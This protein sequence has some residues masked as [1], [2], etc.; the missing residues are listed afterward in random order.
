MWGMSSVVA[1][2]WVI[3]ISPQWTPYPQ[4]WVNPSALGFHPDLRQWNESPIIEINSFWITQI[5]TLHPLLNVAIYLVND[6]P[7]PEPKMTHWTL[8]KQQTSMINKNTYIFTV[9]DRNIQSPS[10]GSQID[11]NLGWRKNH[12]RRSIET[13][14]SQQVPH[15]RR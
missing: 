2:F 4:I 11:T 7:L 8:Q 9:Q 14:S 13:W 5:W 15:L 6:K 12:R 1:H 10:N 3:I